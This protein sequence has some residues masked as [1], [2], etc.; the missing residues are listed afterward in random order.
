ME[1]A[2]KI[3]ANAD[4][5]LSAGK[6]V[7]KFIRKAEIN[8]SEWRPDSVCCAL[9]T[10]ELTRWIQHIYRKYALDDAK[11]RFPEFD[12]DEDGVVTWEEYN[13]VSHDQL[14]SFDDLAVPEDPEQE[15]LKYAS[16]S[17]IYFFFTNHIIAH[18]PYTAQF[19]EII[20]YISLSSIWK[21]G[22]ASTLLMQMAHLG[23]MWQSF[24]PSPTH[25]KW[26]TWL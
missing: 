16:I 4:N 10:E 23:L 12:T 17:F 5:L 24:L 18:R 11:E 26:I 25:L 6:H 7:S 3:D 20:V 8:R 13:M 14:L 1:I 2:R 21:R 15:S 9:S 19:S 22:G